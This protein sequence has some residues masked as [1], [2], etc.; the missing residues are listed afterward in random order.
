MGEDVHDDSNTI[1]SL[2]SHQKHTAYWT[3]NT[4]TLTDNEKLPDFS[5]LVTKNR[6]G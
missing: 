4:L 3:K 5:K 6:C 1:A 2:D